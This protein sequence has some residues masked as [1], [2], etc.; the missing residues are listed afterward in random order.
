MLIFL[1]IASF[2]GYGQDDAIQLKGRV[3]S[4]SNDVSNVLVINLSSK[5]STITDTLGL[6]TIA[7]KLGDPIRFSAVQYLA[8]QIIVTDSILNKGKVLVNLEEKVIN[9]DEVMVTPY[10]LT[11]NI[12]HDIERLGIKPIVTSSSLALPNADIEVV[13]QSERLLLEADSGKYVYYYG[14]ALIINLHKI[15]N[16]TSGRTKSFEDM[17]ARDEIMAIEKEIIAKFS[18]ETMSMDFDIPIE[19]IDGFLTYCL[20]QTDFPELSD[21]PSTIEIWEYLRNKSSEY[22][23]ANN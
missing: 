15:M 9:L 2:S 16:R 19:N 7:V 10:N 18:K 11:G 1:S 12:D 23:K 22:K 20:S 14:I 13:T 5:K 3:K 8:K 17:V 6:F 4:L 21:K